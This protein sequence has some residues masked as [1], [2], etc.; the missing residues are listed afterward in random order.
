METC[1][2]S[3]R[4]RAPLEETHTRAAV[5]QDADQAAEKERRLACLE[6]CLCALRA[7]SRALI[8]AYYQEESR[9][10]IDRRGALAERLGLRRDALANR[11]Q[12][13]RDKLEQCVAGCL[14]KKTAI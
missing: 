4:K 1:K 5:A 8:T 9:G 12:R 3:D 11:A 7:E 2:G 6:D 14:K 13:V 10:R